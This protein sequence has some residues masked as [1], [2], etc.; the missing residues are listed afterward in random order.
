[1]ARTN[2]EKEGIKTHNGAPAK[3]ITAEQALRR[4]VMSCLLWE[5]EF[6]ESGEDIA[7]RIIN[8]VPL[9]EPETVAA[10]AVEARTKMMLRHVP[11]LMIVAMLKSERHKPYVSDVIYQVVNRPDELGELVSIY[12]KINKIE[13]FKKMRKL[14][15]QLKL[16]LARAFTKFNE[17][18][19]AKWNRDAEIKLKDVLFSC[20]AKPNSSEQSILW[21]KLIGGYCKNCG[22]THYNKTTRK[23]EE[24]FGDCTKFEE[25]TLATPDTWEVA[26]SSGGD[27]KDHWTRLLNEGKLGALALLKN[28]RGMHQA[29][30]DQ[31]LVKEV[32]KRT[33]VSKVL[34]F[35]YI[36]A[37]RYVPHLEANLEEALF[38]NLQEGR[39]IKGSTVLYVDV[40]GSMNR[41]LS[42]AHSKKHAAKTNETPMSRMEAACGLAMLLRELCDDIRI[43]TFSEKLVEIPNRH[44]FA[45]RDA[46]V[47]SQR[48]WSTYLGASIKALTASRDTTIYAKDRYGRTVDAFTT[49]GMGL[50]PDRLIVI[51]DEQSDDPV[52]D[53]KGKGYMINVA[54]AENGVGYQ[55]WIHVDGF[56]ASVINWLQ[57]YEDLE[58][59]CR[60]F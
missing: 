45:L 4:S 34:P 17:Y 41:A 55:S 44:G 38:R 1:M 11:L 19:L 40:S 2:V 25:L 58:D 57:M 13:G 52:P 20:H 12:T 14:A 28:L 43:F 35:R 53:P 47:R 8:L 24:Q 30:V 54:S 15:N 10:M 26:L 6:Y 59:F 18:Q 5:K 49:K 9:V 37:S 42:D 29:G 56:S 7:T 16:G 23:R 50:N 51:T 36:A 32:L 22:T 27:K 39:K 46:I 21:K 3:H 48:H 31:A 33:D 60:S